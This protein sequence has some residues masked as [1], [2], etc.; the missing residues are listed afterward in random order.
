MKKLIAV[1]ATAGLCAAAV[2]AFALT[3]T[4]TTNGSTL[5]A[6]LGGTGLTI[7]SVSKTHGA[8]GQFGTYSDFNSLPVTIGNGVVLS[9]GKVNET[10]AAYKSSN[11]TPSTDWEMS[12]TAEFDNYGGS[13]I[14]NFNHSHDVA[15]LE[16]NFTLAADSKVGF[17]FVFGSVEYPNWVN[18]YT[19]AFLAFLDGSDTA[20][21]IVFDANNKPVQVGSSFVSLLTTADTNTAFSGTHG[22]MALKTFTN[23]LSAGTHTLTFE[24]GDVNDGFLDSGV[25][26]SNLRTG[27]SG[28]ITGTYDDDIKDDGSNGPATVPEPGTFLLLGA[29][30]AGL[31]F[32]RK[33]FQK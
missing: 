15:S 9:T 28:T 32:A 8:N 4:Q 27:V 20:N 3:V 14:T 18:N 12:G 2:P 5:Q 17:D 1:V 6:A 33:R 30:L 7:N 23:T 13:N 22:L 29:G 25:F 16:V 24:I 10:T 21:Q 31:G 26:I 11:D 19:D